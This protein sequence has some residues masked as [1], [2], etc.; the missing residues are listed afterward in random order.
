MTGPT[1]AIVGAG[2]S[3][4]L[5]ALHVLRRCP[6]DVRVVLI[7]RHLNFG[8]GQAYST[9]NPSH[10]L[11]VTAGRMSAFHDRPHDFLD[12]LQSQLPEAEDATFAP[13]QMFGD[14][15]RSLLNEEIGRD[16]ARLELV[17]G[18]VRRIEK[19]PDHLTLRMDRDRSLHA[20]LLVLAVG[21]FPPEPP[22]VADMTFYD[23]PLYRPDPWAAEALEGLDPGAPVLLIGTGLTTVDAVISLLDRGHAGPIHALS[24]R[25]LLPRRHVRA[26]AVAMP[27]E[28]FPTEPLALLRFL[29]RRAAA[30]EAKGGGTWQQIMDELRPFT[31]DVWQ[32]MSMLDRR[33]F[34]RHARPWWDVHRHRCAPEV[35]DRIDDARARRQLRVRAG[36]LQ[37]FEVRGDAVDAV[38][39]VRGSDVLET[40]T[41][42]RV[43]NC[44]GPSC[45]YDRIGHP[46]IRALLA[47][48]FVRPDPLRLGLDVSGT[49]A[50]LGT[51][52]AI[53][54]R[55]FAIGPVT[56]GAFWEM[57][58]V[59]DIRR[60]CEMLATHLAG[61][62]GHVRQQRAVA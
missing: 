43:V 31:G 4:T 41:A 2:F 33:R 20:D 35:A 1:I 27:E 34:L 61:R 52:G 28:P 47:D 40:I 8:R 53:S 56:R 62:A 25:G 55:I 50:V 37:R 32:A 26:A 42:A 9:G 59:P 60:Q 24:R 57:T 16:G 22:V 38:F 58:A 36:R 13:R 7:E 17:H 5:L 21:N 29:R 54:P 14:Y 12:W 23:G 11:N 46:L 44:S 48:G 45:D 6:P 30:A 19:A 15:V 10:L 39:R 49:C 18:D 3:G 51:D